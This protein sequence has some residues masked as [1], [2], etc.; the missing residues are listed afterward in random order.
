MLAGAT[1]T[2]EDF[3]VA[4]RVE[5]LWV[6][7]FLAELVVA[8]FLVEEETFLVSAGLDGVWVAEVLA[9]AALGLDDEVAGF[10]LEDVE[11]LVLEVLL[12]LTFGVAEEGTVACF[13]VVAAGIMGSLKL[14]LGKMESFGQETD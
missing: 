2:A 14:Q 5:D 8:V 11:G 9:V 1:G 7:S 10:V 6:E 13:V 12:T 4:L 3:E